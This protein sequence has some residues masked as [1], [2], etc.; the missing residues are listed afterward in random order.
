[1]VRISAIA[2]DALLELVGRQMIQELGEDG[3]SGIH[4][5]LL[6][7]NAV[8]GHPALAHVLLPSISNRKIRVTAYRVQYVLVTTISPILAG[9][10]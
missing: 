8:G 3:L 7:I 9:H 10:Y 5:S 4:H 2:L 6:T 1:M